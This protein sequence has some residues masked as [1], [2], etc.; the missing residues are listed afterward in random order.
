[1][2]QD[3]TLNVK[4]S[5]SQL[6]KLKSGVKS[7]TKVTLNHSSNMIG[8]SIDETNFRHKLLLSGTQVLRLRKAF[9]NNLSANVKL[10][11]MKLSKMVQLGGFFL[12]F[13]I[14]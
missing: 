9:A 8:D 4:L 13:L 14:K 7:G 10:S 12:L 1:M 11:K 3:N 2:T 6:N 5:K